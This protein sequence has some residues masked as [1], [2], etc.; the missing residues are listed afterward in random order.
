MTLGIEP[1]QQAVIDRI[2]AALPSLVENLNADSRLPWVHDLKP[3]DLSISRTPPTF[4]D[5]DAFKSAAQ[6]VTKLVIRED[7]TSNRIRADLIGTRLVVFETVDESKVLMAD[8][9]FHDRGEGI[10]GFS[11]I[12]FDDAG[13]L[14]NVYRAKS[15]KDGTLLGRNSGEYLQ[16][17]LTGL[18]L[19]SADDH[20]PASGTNCVVVDGI[21]LYQHKRIF[22]SDS[23]YMESQVQLAPRT[24]PRI[25]NEL[26][27]EFK[28]YNYGTR[29]PLI[30]KS[31]QEQEY[32]A[33]IGSQLEQ[34]NE[35]WWVSEDMTKLAWDV[36]L[37]GTDPEDLSE[38]ELPTPAGIMW[39]NGGGG[40]V[41]MSKH[42]P[43]KDFLLTGDT[44]SELMSVNAIIWYTP[45]IKIP[46]LK[47]GKPRFMGL[48]A[49]PSIVR[50]TTLWNSIVSP[51]DIE[52]N[53]FEV[54]RIPT[55]VTYYKLKYLP[56][57]MAL[58][59]MRLARE[60]SLGQTTSETVGGSPNRKKNRL[61]RIDTVTCASLR[62]Q[63]YLSEAEREAEARDYSH[64]WIV[65]GHMRNQPVGPRNTEGGQKH[66]RVWIAPYV[67]G[68][69]DKPLILKD[70]VQLFIS[71]ARENIT[72]HP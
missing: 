45:T 12:E 42:L 61:R 64:R 19:N 68:P 40:P 14:T 2:N 13:E 10:I 30:E 37:S 47:V 48:T 58:I 8:F 55:Y 22:D 6:A 29:F 27:K 67:K 60:E 28:N 62:R 43:E 63:R 18:L 24:M 7:D 54:H 5:G 21:R 31:Q 49:S 36:A 20:E 44:Q 46:G 9:S 69:E 15:Y 16:N 57:K 71:S 52:S 32:Y 50:D 26:A 53:I 51:I 39:L 72:P 41:L 33:Q 23:G 65:R 25:R 1:D 70:R 59:V 3:S 38:K 34:S 56:R 17:L 4:V 11:T 35:M 66:L